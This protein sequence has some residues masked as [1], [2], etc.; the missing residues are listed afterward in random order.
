MEF[1]IGV[2]II[3]ILVMLVFIVIK[4]KQEKSIDTI[5]PTLKVVEK[6]SVTETTS[7]L[8]DEL[9]VP[10]EIISYKKFDVQKS[11]NSPHSLAL[12][13]K[14]IDQIGNL[15]QVTNS[16]ND[17]IRT[18]KKVIIK[19]TKE[20]TEKLKSGEYTLMNAK[21]SSD[22]FRTI[23]VDGNSKIK[24]HGVVELKKI[25]QLNPAQLANVAFG[26][27]TIVT[28]QEHLDRINQQLT[29]MD[30]KLDTLLR[31]FNNDKFG[32]IN[33]SIRYYK[34]ILPSIIDQ[35]SFSTTYLMKVEDISA[36]AYKQL[37]SVIRELNAILPRT[38]EF[39][40]TKFKLDGN[41]VGIKEL[42]SEFEEQLLL[43]YGT[44]ELLSISLKMTIHFGISK[45]LSNNKLLD[46]EQ[47]FK[48][49]NSLQTN[50]ESSLLEK[51]TDLNARFR[52]T[53]TIESKKV[54]VFE[55]HAALLEIINSNKASTEQY[56]EAHKNG[57]SISSDGPVALQVEYDEYQKVIAVHRL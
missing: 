31:K 35:D 34:S 5:Q 43:A 11:N 13:N 22:Q 51:A 23:A 20:V 53:S 21:A 30:N 37:E 2:V 47:Y 36:E 41:I 3:I 29:S 19:F 9:D 16:A 10:W 1:L 4:N 38:S 57:L 33:G 28:S 12:S 55:Q 49:L 14:L 6:D 8:V 7:P 40:N 45:E 46:I 24:G 25:K 15:M 27:M 48:Q 52:R 39:K 44:L 32:F 50:F 26:V 17:L 42:I 56:I 54:S 18:D